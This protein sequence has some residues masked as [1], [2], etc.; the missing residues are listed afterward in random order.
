ML[1]PLLAL[2]LGSMQLSAQPVITNQ[3]ADQTVVLG[4]N[5]TFSVM[6]TGLGPLTYQWQLN[7]TNVFTNGIITTVAGNAN[8]GYYGDGGAA[9]NAF[10][11]GP[12]A[13]ATDT[14]GNMLIADTWNNRIRKVDTNGI[15]STVAGIGTS[16]SSGDGGAATNASLYW[17]YAVAL[18][19]F[20]DLFI[21]EYGNNRVRK[22][23][24]NGVITT[25]AGGGAGGD[26]GMATNALLKRAVGVAV[27]T[28]GNLF[29]ADMGNNRI[30]KVDTNGIISTVAGSGTGVGGG[31]SGDGGA[32]TNAKLSEPFGVALD[33][34]GNLFIADYNNFRIREVNTNGIITTVAGNGSAG[35]AVDGG[36]S[37]QYPLMESPRNL[38]GHIWLYL[39]R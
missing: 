36:A 3:P 27:D 39:H 1:L 8:T 5:A 7:V 19:S 9:T 25:V 32:A 10:L 13:V 4:G 11:N 33:N 12:Y 38:R 17:P 22:V 24:T 28:A 20:G 6:A 2:M 23:D 37:Y 34:S 35:F 30:R 29:I 14:T 18:D 21:A 26:G 16:G 15:I 31:F